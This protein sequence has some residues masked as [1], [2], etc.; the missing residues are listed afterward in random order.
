MLVFETD[1]FALELLLKEN[2]K[3]ILSAVNT[4]TLYFKKKIVF[5]ACSSSKDGGFPQSKL[6]SQRTVLGSLSD[7]K[8]LSGNKG[9]VEKAL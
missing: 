6:L 9:E 2:V 4:A 5:I 8:A 3:K 1:T 7:I